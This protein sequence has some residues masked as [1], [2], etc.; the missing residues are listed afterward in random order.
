MELKCVLEEVVR[1]E[2]LNSKLYLSGIEIGLQLDDV[3]PL[4]SPNCTLV[5]L[6][7]NNNEDNAGRELSP[8]CTLVELKFVLLLLLL[9][10]FRAPNCTLVELK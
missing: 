7:C 9:C 6:K 10:S 4:W 2:F 3:R 1:Y 5:E 8:N